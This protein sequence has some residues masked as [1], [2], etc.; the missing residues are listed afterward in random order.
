MVIVTCDGKLLR[1]LSE[2]VELTIEIPTEPG[3]YREVKLLPPLSMLS[4]QN[5]WKEMVMSIIRNPRVEERQPVLRS[6]HGAEF[7]ARL[8]NAPVVTQVPNAPLT[9]GTNGYI[10]HFVSRN[11]VL[12]PKTTA[13]CVPYSTAQVSLLMQ[14][15]HAAFAEHVPFSLAPET[16]WYMIAH[17]VAVHIR[18]NVDRYRGYFTSSPEKDT[19]HVR[20]DTLVYGSPDNLWGRSINKIRDPIAEKVP[21]PTIQLLLPQFSTSSFESDT[22][23]LVLFLDIISNYYDALVYTLCGVP[24]VRVEGTVDDWQTVVNHAEM[25]QSEFSGLKPYFK[26]LL[27]VLREIAGAVGGQEPDPEFWASIYKYKDKVSSG[28]PYINGWITAFFAHTL[29][30]CE[31]AMRQNPDW[32]SRAIRTKSAP[33]QNPDRG[34]VRV[35]FP[36]RFA[37]RQNLDWRRTAESPFGG[38]TS[39]Q[40]P[41]HLSKVPFIWDYFGTQINMAFMTGMMGVEYDGF[42]NPKLGYAVLEDT[43]QPNQL[44]DLTLE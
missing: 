25:A 3:N 32:R 33:R 19:I 37:P 28:G 27:P 35:P 11:M 29:T 22:A 26:D 17:E 6:Q 20:D 14:A 40:L 30:P 18:L 7:L 10:A 4:A 43:G 39:M 16:A 2:D 41:V 1:R 12:L 34:W 5:L 21:Q 36:T 24:A 38:L 8:L 44:E 9:S 15:L 42:L 31:S 23:L 13:R